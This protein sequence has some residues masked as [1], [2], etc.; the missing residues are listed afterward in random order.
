MGEAPSRCRSCGAP[1]VWAT[2]PAGKLIPLDP[3]PVDD[4]NLAVHRDEDGIHLYARVLKKGEEPAEH[5]RRGV[6]HFTTCPQ[7]DQHRRRGRAES[8]TC[9]PVTLEVDGEQV[10]A[11]IRT[12]GPVTD[13]DRA[14]IAAAVRALR[15]RA[16]ADPEAAARQAERQA[17]AIDRMRA[18]RGAAGRSP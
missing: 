8:P 4:G 15:R 1:I 12:A 13:A 17:A 14:I 18:R 10:D 7:A 11:R 2:T 6:S 3:Q 5:E 16:E 9:K